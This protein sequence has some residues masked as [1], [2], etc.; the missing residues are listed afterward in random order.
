MTYDANNRI[1]KTEIRDPLLKLTTI[2]YNSYGM[3]SDVTD[4]NL[5]TTWFF[6]ENA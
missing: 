4:P 2:N 6:Y 5:N 1:T 3:P